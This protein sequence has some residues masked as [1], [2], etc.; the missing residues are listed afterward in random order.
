MTEDFFKENQDYNNVY[1]MVVDAKG[2]SKL[3]RDNDLD[4]VDQAFDEFERVV[5][6]SVTNEKK[7]RRVQFA[8]FWGWQGDGGLCIFYDE[9][10]SK[11]REAAI[12]SAKG[13]LVEIPHLNQ[14]LERSKIV[15]EIHVRIAL[16]KGGIRYKGFMKRGS[17]HSAELNLI[18][19]AEKVIPMDCLA[20]SADVF[21][22]CGSMKKEFLKAEGAFE[23]KTFYLYSERLKNDVC[24]DW[25][26]NVSRTGEMNIVGLDSNIPPAELGLS[27]LFSQRAETTEYSRLINAAQEC[28][29]VSGIS[30]QGFQ[31]DFSDDLLFKKA[32]EGVEI[33][34]LVADPEVTISIKRTAHQMP[35]WADYAMNTG[36]HNQKSIQSL[37]KRVRLIN[38]RIEE[39]QSKKKKIIS[40]KY[41][42]TFP[43]AILRVD[44]IL[45][46]SPYFAR[47][48][49]LKTFTLKLREGKL[50][51]QVVGN[52]NAVWEDSRYSRSD[53]RNPKGSK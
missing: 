21:D 37:I 13:I 9:Q 38:R 26:E 53:A 27:G 17:I 10:E 6:E 35:A 3:V 7:Q 29:W 8:E 43:A 2:H 5:S 16:H 22:K 31:E 18:A 36:S 47:R 48:L 19:H 33:R 15:G 30:L 39:N 34:F 25:K 24:K 42:S 46:F 12:F 51:E 14:K 44:S 49:G 40:L 32:I 50:Y 1:F 4:K 11:A 41:Y 20:I 45:Y 52:F 23:N 28:I